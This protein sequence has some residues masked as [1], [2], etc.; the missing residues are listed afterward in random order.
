M[1]SATLLTAS[2]QHRHNLDSHSE[3]AY[4]LLKEKITTLAL[5]PATLL[6][7]TKLMTELNLGRTPIREALQRLAYEHLV[8]ILPRRGTIVADLNLSDIQKI[9]EVR[10]EL[11]PYAAQLAAGRA[12]PEQIA[13][14]ERLFNGVDELIRQG[15]PHQL[16]CLDHQAH[17]LLVQA[18]QN[19]FLEEILEQ[20]YTHIL[21][22]WYL[23]LHKV[24]RLAEAIEE[25]RH[26]I[27][28]V[29]AGDGERAAQIMRAH[30]T[31]F[32]SEFMAVL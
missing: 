3:T 31:G 23:S 19:E 13:A 30:L 8:V 28:A 25:H 27:A 10:L 14:M 7:E 17:R 6:N 26:I 11:E 5:P 21:R 2:R 29:K 20:L 32:Q 9:F 16:I 24:S 4:R 15:N 1:L 12:T 18:A 22:L